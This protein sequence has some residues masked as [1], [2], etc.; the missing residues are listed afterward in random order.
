MIGWFD[1][2][3][4]SEGWFDDEAVSVGWF[5]REFVGTGSGG[6]LT[7]VNLAA[8]MSMTPAISQRK[9]LSLPSGLTLTPTANPGA[10]VSLSAFF[11]FGSGS[12]VEYGAGNY[13]D[14]VYGG[15]TSPGMSFARQQARSLTT[16]LTLS[17]AMT[18]LQGNSRVLNAIL[19]LTPALKKMV[20][21]SVVGS[22][23]MSPSM[24]P[25]AKVFKTLAAALT[26]SGSMPKRV[27]YFKTLSVNLTVAPT[28]AA[29]RVFKRTIALT[30]LSLVSGLSFISQKLR[31]FTF[32]C[33]MTMQPTMTNRSQSFV[34]M[35]ISLNLNPLVLK[36][37]PIGVPLG[38]SLGAAMQDRKIKY[39]ILNST[40]PLSGA[41]GRRVLRFLNMSASMPLTSGMVHVFKGKR[42]MSVNLSLNP[43]GR[44]TM[45]IAF[46]RGLNLM[47]EYAV[48]PIRARPVFNVSM[49]LT[50][51]SHKSKFNNFSL[52]LTIGPT[53]S[54]LSLKRISPTMSLTP[55]M[56][57]RVP[58]RVQV[59]LLLVPF[60]HD[61]L[62][63]PKWLLEA[64][65]VMV[66]K[67]KVRRRNYKR[68]NAKSVLLSVTLGEANLLNAE[69]KGN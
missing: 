38:L 50:A 9:G 58:Q 5:D 49:P 62:A 14:A 37:I 15:G 60:E 6:T 57:R 19:S 28:Q 67:V 45:F 47:P 63:E 22:L 56:K 4:R 48:H 55:V 69:L 51:T 52:A 18:P 27:S 39:L 10:R 61:Q 43:S 20:P 33:G 29:K 35:P 53:Q 25:R 41:Q 17:P 3:L 36:K 2:Q 34:A 24:A 66:A 59:V 46:P 64:S 42:A 65:T 54:N 13:G 26:L 8:S 44:K 21:K 40:M 30:S 23:A 7:P 32:D 16:A 11:G 31:S 68:S 1:P 12:P